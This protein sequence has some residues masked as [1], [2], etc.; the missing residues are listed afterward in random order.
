MNDPAHN[1]APKLSKRLGPGFYVL[2]A[3]MWLWPLVVLLATFRWHNPSVGLRLLCKSTWV[4]FAGVCQS[5]L[6][7]MW[8]ADK[9]GVTKDKWLWIL[10]SVSVAS[11]F[12]L[13]FGLGTWEWSYHNFGLSRNWTYSGNLF[14]SFL[15]HIL[16]VGI[17][18]ELL[19]GSASDGGLV[20]Y[21]TPDASCPA[22]EEGWMDRVWT[23]EGISD[24]F[25]GN[26]GEFDVKDE[27]RRVSEDMQQFHSA[28][29]NADVSDHYYWDDVLDAETDDYL[30]N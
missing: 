27:A 1:T 18:V 30:E 8:Q 10:I 5:W 9:R 16:P 24:D 14:L 28:H 3:A 26:H 12:L 25:Y 7:W 13:P 15:L 21:Q 4:L 20:D 11:L 22:G 6:M 23:G 2:L 17:F 29:P 19:N